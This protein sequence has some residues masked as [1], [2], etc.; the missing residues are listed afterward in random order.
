MIG[1][2]PLVFD[3]RRVRAH[4]ERAAANGPGFLREMAARDLLDRLLSVSRTFERGVELGGAGD[5]KS[6]V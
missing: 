1:S 3:R 5:R 6:V 2:P 4:R